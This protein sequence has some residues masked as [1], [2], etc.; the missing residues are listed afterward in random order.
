MNI[1]NVSQFKKA[2]KDA[3]VNKQ[4][5]HTLNTRFGDMGIRK[6]SI[7]QS[8]S[9]AF[10]T[11]KEGKMTDSWCEFEKA[12]NYEFDGSNIVK[13]FWGEGEKREHILTYTFLSL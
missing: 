6:L 12:A 11:M 9:F 13:I 8:N 2:L 4:D 1:S 7:V 10:S 5:I 3:L